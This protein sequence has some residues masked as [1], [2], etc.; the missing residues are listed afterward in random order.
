MFLDLQRRQEELE[1]RA[2]ELARKEEELRTQSGTGEMYL[3][4]L[5]ITYNRKPSQTNETKLQT[6]LRQNFLG[7]A[8]IILGTLP[9]TKLAFVEAKN[10][11][12]HWP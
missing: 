11:K 9:Y 5:I 4:T 8:C 2:Q 1:R 3:Y 7:I 12:K 6:I 10:M